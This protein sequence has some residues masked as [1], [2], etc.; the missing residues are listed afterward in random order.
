[1]IKKHDPD[2]HI[3]KFWNMNLWCAPT[4]ISWDN[5]WVHYAFTEGYHPARAGVL[6]MQTLQKLWGKPCAVDIEDYYKYMSFCG[7]VDFIWQFFDNLTGAQQVY[8]DATLENMVVHRE[9]II[10]IDPGYDRGFKCRE[11]DM[12]KLLQSARGWDQMRR[13]QPYEAEP[14]GEPAVVASYMTHLH[15]LM[16][17][18]HP[19]YAI[20]WAMTELQEARDYLD[21]L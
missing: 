5:G 3:F 8:G 20:H 13:G 1:M 10:F 17:H 9:R 11:N 16:R 2:K 19:G 12:G 4:S 18:K 15:R 14:F 7:E 6:V 21:A